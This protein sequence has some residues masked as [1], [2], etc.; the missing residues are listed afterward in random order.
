MIK[1]YRPTD[2]NNGELVFV[3]H[4]REVFTLSE[5]YVVRKWKGVYKSDPRDLGTVPSYFV[6]SMG[7]VIEKKK[8][9]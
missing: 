6:V 2:V 9:R 4:L 5:P 8:Q 7:I 3:K 1:V